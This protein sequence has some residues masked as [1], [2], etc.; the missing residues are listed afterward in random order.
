MLFCLG[1]LHGS[2]GTNQSNKLHSKLGPNFKFI[3]II[4]SE[5]ECKYLLPSA[6]AILSLRFTFQ[7][8]EVN[9]YLRKSDFT[10][11][12]PFTTPLW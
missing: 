2:G 4:G 10:K 6:T 11:F 7:G 3:S 1:S 9:F 12:H 5:G 8:K